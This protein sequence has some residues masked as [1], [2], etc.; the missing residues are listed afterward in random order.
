MNSQVASSLLLLGC[1]TVA[2]TGPSTAPAAVASFNQ[3][4]FSFASQIL[5]THTHME[6]TTITNCAQRKAGRKLL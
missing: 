3:G 4:Q 1:V 6:N 2:M 5:G